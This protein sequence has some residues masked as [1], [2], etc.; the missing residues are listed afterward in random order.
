MIIEKLFDAFYEEASRFI[1]KWRISIFF[2]SWVIASEAIKVLLKFEF[3]TG[4][5]ADGGTAVLN[6]LTSI[7]LYKLFFLAITAFYLGPVIANKSAFFLLK[8]QMTYADNLFVAV[9]KAVSQTDLN[10]SAMQLT[11]ARDQAVHAEKQIERRKA[12]NES[13]ITIVLLGGALLFEAP[14]APQILIVSFF[15]WV[16]LAYRLVQ[17][18][19]ILYV[20]K[21]YYFKLLSAKASRVLQK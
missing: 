13:Y 4:S 5:L 10:N 1:T 21:I 9:D 6:S 7:P 3:W 14:Y 17:K 2:A 11:A 16:V 20:S 8:W 12:V 18:M 19:L 15:V